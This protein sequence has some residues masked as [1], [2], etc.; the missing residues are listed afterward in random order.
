MIMLS[1]RGPDGGTMSNKE[2]GM[3]TDNLSDDLVGKRIAFLSITRWNS[4]RATR[5]VHGIL[6]DKD[7]VW[8]LVD[9][10]GY[11]GFMVRPEEIISIVE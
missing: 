3:K 11:K 4:R 7:K 10:G 5:K 9:F 8:A 6:K 2:K 1:G